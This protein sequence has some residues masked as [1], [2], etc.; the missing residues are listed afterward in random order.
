[1]AKIAYYVTNHGL[2]HATRTIA[3]VR[4]LFKES[5]ELLITFI[6]SGRTRNFLKESLSHYK[7]RTSFYESS[8]DVGLKLKSF[9]EP[10]IN[11]MK[12]ELLHY[13][14]NVEWTIK[15]ESEDL[16]DHDLIISDVVPHA[17]EVAE[18][19][20]IPSVLLSNF[21]WYE[22]YKGILKK[23]QNVESLD[24]MYS[25][26][27]YSI[28]LASYSE[29]NYGKFVKRRWIARKPNEIDSKMIRNNISSQRYQKIVYLGIGMSVSM[30]NDLDEMIKANQEYAFV[31]PSGFQRKYPNVFVI[32][33]NYLESQNYV[34]ASDICVIKSGWSTVS[35]CITMGKPTI[36]IERK[37][38]PEDVNT[39]KFLKKKYGI[40]SVPFKDLESLDFKEIKKPSKT[41]TNDERIVSDLLKVIKEAS[42]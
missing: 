27:T 33:K 39:Q 41:E 28:Q 16:K 35:E 42:K 3:V 20:N 30:E 22:M 13:I 9:D 10:N 14:N 24:E 2:G 15:R 29:K 40:K 34:Y 7:N 4:E 1:M 18:K 36:V 31:V 32:P 19:L 25:K 12:K 6:T 5:E 26:A 38:I 11:E 23:E 21:T 17:F 8:L 37:N